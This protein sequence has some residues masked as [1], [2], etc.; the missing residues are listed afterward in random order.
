MPR[1]NEGEQTGVG[2]SKC[3]DFTDAVLG[4]SD[5]MRRSAQDKRTGQQVSTQTVRRRLLHHGFSARRPCLRMPLTLHQRQE[6]LQWCDQRRTWCTNACSRHRHTGPSSGMMVRGAIGYTSRSPFVRIDVT[7]N[8]ARYIY[9]VLQLVAL[10]FIRDLRNP[11]FK[12]DNA[13]LP[14][15]YRPS[16]IRKMFDCCPGLHVHLIFQQ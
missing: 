12:Q 6:R 14:V 16:L 15:L 2:S 4:R 10:P 13:R 7:F 5:K 9:G 3:F 11:S 8:S 1:R